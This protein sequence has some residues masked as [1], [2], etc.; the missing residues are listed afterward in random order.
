MHRA[1]RARRSPTR[2]PRYDTLQPGALGR[3]RRPRRRSRSPSTGSTPPSRSGSPAAAQF[4][5]APRLHGA[6]TSPT[7][8]GPAAERSRPSRS[9]TRCE[10][11]GA[12]GLPARQRLRPGHHRARRG[13]QRASTATPRRSCRR[14][15]TTSRSARS[16]SGRPRPSSSASP[17]SSCRPAIIDKDNGPELGL[18][19]RARSPQLALGLS[20]ATS[21]PRAGRSRS[22][23]STPSS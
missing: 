22:T 17:A 11:G 20:R 18:P 4:G 13:G 19:R 5:A 6:R 16:R 14:T 15:T 1:G 12:L 8:R 10:I 2:S 9:T 7:S 3:R 23:P 21:S